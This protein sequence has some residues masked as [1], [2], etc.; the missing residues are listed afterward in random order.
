[1]GIAFEMALWSVDPI[2]GLN[3]PVRAA[4]AQEIIGLAKAGECDPERLCETALTAVR[5]VDPLLRS[6]PS[7][8]ILEDGSAAEG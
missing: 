8:D 5:P 1:M 4:L 7:V 2:P 3:D 6:P